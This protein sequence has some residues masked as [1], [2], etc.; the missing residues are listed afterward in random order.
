MLFIP[1]PASDLPALR[2]SAG[3]A[4]RIIALGAD[5]TPTDIISEPEN[6]PDA[7]TTV[8]A[9][10]EGFGELSGQFPMPTVAAAPK[11]G[12]MQRIPPEHAEQTVEHG[13]RTATKSS[14]GDRSNTLCAALW[15]ACSRG[16]PIVERTAREGGNTIVVTLGKVGIAIEV[17][18]GHE[19]SDAAIKMPLPGLPGGPKLN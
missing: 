11:I 1:I 13:V 10:V 6:H 9:R 19:P 8:V 4:C 15:L 16:D 7:W 5:G 14:E 18:G 12:N 2:S 17:R 3:V